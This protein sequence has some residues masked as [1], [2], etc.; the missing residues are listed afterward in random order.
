MLLFNNWNLIGQTDQSD[1]QVYGQ[2]QSWHQHY[3]FI[4]SSSCKEQMCSM[5]RNIVLSSLLSKQKPSASVARNDVYQQGVRDVSKIYTEERFLSFRF[6][7]TLVLL[8][9]LLE[10]LQVL[11][12]FFLH[13]LKKFDSLCM[14]AF[15][16]CKQGLFQL[17]M[18]SRVTR[19]G[20][21]KSVKP[22]EGSVVSEMM[23][24]TTPHTPYRLNYRLPS[25]C[26]NTTLIN[27]LKNYLASLSGLPAIAFWTPHLWTWS[28]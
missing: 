22:C 8:P 9:L 28:V 23:R 25:L 16:I 27:M 2:R 24:N 12:C 20:S 7:L 4:L 3:E 6:L 13:L 1:G 17:S 5:Y 15:L 19:K 18:L 26:Q 14:S 11:L 10:K 21:A